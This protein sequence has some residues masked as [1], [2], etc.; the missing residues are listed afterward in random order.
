MSMWILYPDQL[1]ANP[2]ILGGKAEGLI[3]LHRA[4]LSVP[5]FCMIPAEVA[6]VRP[7]DNDPAAARVLHEAFTSLNVPPFQGVAIRSS[8]DIEDGIKRSCAGIFETVFVNRVEEVIPAINRVCDSVQQRKVQDHYQYIKNENS[9]IRMAVVL[10]AA[11]APHMAGVLFSAHPA[12]A[13][14]GECYVEIVFGLGGGLVDG[15][16]TPSR[17]HISLASCTVAKS[18]SGPDGP[19]SISPETAKELVRVLEIMEHLLDEPVDIEWAAD[20]TRLWF[21][22]ARPLTALKPDKKLLPPVC[23]TSWFFD[24]RFTEPIRPFTRRTLLPLIGKTAIQDALIMRRRAAPDPLFYFFGGQAY[25]PHQAYRDMLGGAPR[26]WLSPDL[27]P[28]FSPECVCKEIP[29]TASMW[30]YAWSAMRAVYKNRR[31]VFRNLSAWESFKSDLVDLLATPM[32]DVL[33]SRDMWEAAWRQ[34][35]AFTERFLQIHRWSILWADYFHRAFLLFL[36]AFPRSFA[37]RIERRIWDQIHLVTA[38]ANTA[39]SAVTHASD[40]STRRTFAM[41]FGHRS[42][43]LDYAVKTWAEQI[44]P[45]QFL[46]ARQIVESVSTS[47][48]ALL[49]NTRIRNI[50]ALYRRLMEMRE[51]QRFEWERILARQ[52]GMVMCAAQCLVAQNRLPDMD[53]VWFLEPRELLAALFDG[54]P[55]D[56]ET[57]RARRHLFRLEKHFD[58]P[59]FVGPYGAPILP[60]GDQIFG[61]GASPGTLRGRTWKPTRPDAPVPPFSEPVIA[62]LSALD[63]AQ[64]PLL[65]R[66]QGVII[67]RGGLLSHAAI[68]AR[69][70]GIPLVIGVSGAVQGLQTGQEVT[71]DGIQGWIIIHPKQ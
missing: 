21:L 56:Q 20:D 44:L 27:R 30:D 34:Y 68:L 48:H 37:R 10:Q 60:I 47:P 59:P 26:W 61:I 52:R 25:V 8:A 17:F 39:W 22:Q 41:R 15:S 53:A 1:P 38:E 58:K 14:P 54:T 42:A 3:R 2:G 29:R 31:D 6:L 69:E 40:D 67:E 62:V 7:W 35:D 36:C 16:H 65:T 28:L 9:S 43:S 70:Y 51:E 46:G 19:A 11:I 66:V 63:P 55:P 71:M 32:P 12:C 5:P 33:N 23:A 57:I 24:Q 4:G 13:C 64:T 49:P 45:E 50:R 18:E